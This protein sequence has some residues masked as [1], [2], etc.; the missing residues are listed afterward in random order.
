MRS[1]LRAPLLIVDEKIEN[2]N[3]QDQGE[4]CT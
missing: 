3:I 4:I 2:Q 1:I